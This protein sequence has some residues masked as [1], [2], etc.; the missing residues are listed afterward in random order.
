MRFAAVVSEGRCAG[1]N[2]VGAVFGS[3]LS[4]GLMPSEK[5]QYDFYNKEKFKKFKK[6]WITALKKHPLTGKQLPKLGTAALIL[7]MNYRN[8]LAT[9]NYQQDLIVC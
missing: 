6:Q 5:M 1:R 2:G 9:K 8:L 7:T 3:K 4:K